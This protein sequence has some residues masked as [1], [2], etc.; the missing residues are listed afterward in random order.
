V[1]GKHKTEVLVV[2]AGPVGLFTALRLRQRGVGVEIADKLERTGA[3]SYALALHPESLELLDE[4]GVADE[5]VSQGYRVDKIGFFEGENR[6]AEVRIPELQAKF[7]FVVVLPQRILE[8]TLEQHLQKK[9]VKVQWNHRVQDLQ[10][11]ALGVSAEVARL[12]RVACGYPIARMEWMVVKTHRSTSPFVVGA[13]GYHSFVRGRLNIEYNSIADEVAFSVFE[14]DCPT[15]LQNEVRVIL[16]DDATCVLWPMPE[17]RC[18]WS[19]QTE[20]PE[21]HEPTLDYLNSL[22]RSRASW[23]PAANGEIHWSS[24]VRFD[25]RLVDSFGHGRIW[26][27]GDSAHLTSP[28]GV[29]SMNAGLSEAEDLARRIAEVLRSDGSL[30]LLGEYNDRQRMAWRALMNLD[31]DLRPTTAATEWVQG[32]AVRILSSIPA[33]GENL[34]TLLAQVGLAWPN[35]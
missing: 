4:A 27:A 32:R 34:S 33:T 25:R 29:Q 5:I 24:V 35:P 15:D 22:I 26:L 19:F 30:D 17:N 31:D 23:F 1:F 14:F 12:D 9:K 7:P 28:V 6:R 2:G 11:D 3:H 21:R 8:S 13:D 18:R 16:D 10:E 20:Q